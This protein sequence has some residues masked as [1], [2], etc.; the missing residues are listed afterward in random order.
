VKVS[1]LPGNTGPIWAVSVLA[2]SLA[3]CTAEVTGVEKRP[4]SGSGGSAGSSSSAGG[5]TMVSPQDCDGDEIAMP[6]RLVR[7][8]FNQIASSLRP[9]FGDAFAASVLKTNQIPPTTERTFPPLGDTSEGSTY[10][11]AKWQ[12]SEAIAE[13]AGNYVFDNFATVTACA[14]PPSADCAQA[15]LTKHAEG[16]Y[17]RPLS[18][19]EKTSLLQ[20]YTE[21]VTAGGTVQQG[22]QAGVRAIYDSPEFLYRSEFGADAKTGPLTPYELASQL[23]YFLTDGPPDAPLLAAAAQNQLLTDA[24]LGAQVDRLLA[25]PGTK[26]NLQDTVFASFGIARVLSVVI[27]GLPPDAFNNGVAAS[28]FRESQLFINNVLWSGGLV[29]DLTTSR[30]SFINTQLAP[31]YGVPAPTAG[32]DADGFGPV[33]LPENRAGI[34][35]SAGFLTSRSRPD[36]PSVVGRGLSVNDAILCQQN[37]AFP[38]SLA[39]QI[40]QVTMLQTNLS[41][42]EKATYRAN[43]A[44]CVGCHPSFD[45]Y[46]LSLDNFDVIGRFRTLDTEGRP[47]DASV[48]LPPVAGG[49]PAANAVE[50]GKALADSGAFTTCLGT[51]LMT[52]ALAET[53]VASKSCAAKAVA[54]SFAQSD[55]SFG[56]LV[57]A[58]ALSK[59]LTQRSGG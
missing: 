18:D 34:I 1:K 14:A 19:R 35:T 11:D 39:D 29:S 26:A 3:A 7:L 12:S 46:G 58:V 20:V 33:D 48:T 9:V 24:Q 37:P 16:A 57:R 55:H 53:G 59:A 30:K 22:V 10:I 42:R 23:S 40:K 2:L 32:L 36:Q 44:P 41:E 15:F 4:N 13:N 50:M 31:L 52:Y 27:D 47:I 6:K 21:V 17:R 49:K 56:A 43:N 54:N 45:P 25:M 28:M 5:S 51:K 8:S 38:D